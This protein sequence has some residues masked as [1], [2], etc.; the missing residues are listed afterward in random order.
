MATQASGVAIVCTLLFLE[1][2]GLPLPV[3]P[4]EAVLIGAG[5]VVASGGAPVWLMAPLAYLAVICGVLTG[6]SWARRI[7]PKRV[8][9]LAARLHAGGPYDRAAAR[10]RKASP[11]QIAASRLLPG[12][13]VYT[14]LVAGAVGL[15]LG[16]FMTG[17]VPA[18]ALWVVTFMGLG[19]FVGAPVERLLGRFE[20]YGLR[21]VVVAA[22]VVVWVVAARWMPVAKPAAAADPARGRWRLAVAFALDL[23]AVSSVAGALSLFTHLTG[24]DSDELA[25]VAAIFAILGVLYLVVARQT[26]GY[27]LGEALLDVRY[28]PPRRPRLQRLG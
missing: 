13:R 18:S 8:H 15:N 27:T 21:V 17:V 24:G 19:L 16:R 3:A 1:E 26:V 10:L 28:H 6:Y 23:V 12:L 5:L 22:V 11:L 9:A 14:S 4:G 25:F 7:G 2:A 20:A